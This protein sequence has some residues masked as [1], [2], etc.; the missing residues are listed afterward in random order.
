MT[1]DLG[2]PH[3]RFFKEVWSRKAVSRDFLCR[4]LPRAVVN[5]LDLRLWN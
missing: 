5:L 4:Y 2:N 3:D 1:P